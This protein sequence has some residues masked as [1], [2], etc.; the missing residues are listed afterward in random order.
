MSRTGELLK[1]IFHLFAHHD[2]PGKIARV[3]KD[4][5][6]VGE[7]KERQS[8]GGGTNSGGAKMVAHK[9]GPSPFS[10][11]GGGGF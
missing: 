11:T 5:E 9:G 10:E 4:P 2:A 1:N 3:D 6:K 7:G 8:G